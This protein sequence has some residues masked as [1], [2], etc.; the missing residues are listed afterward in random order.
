LKAGLNTSAE[1]LVKKIEGELKKATK[2]LIALDK[3]FDRFDDR[4]TIQTRDQEQ[5]VRKLEGGGR[6]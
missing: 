5:R 1:A 4:I 3:K 6:R 2:A